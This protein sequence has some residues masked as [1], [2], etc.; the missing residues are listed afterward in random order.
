MTRKEGIKKIAE[1]GKY[2]AMTALGTYMI[3]NP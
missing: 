2:A 3:L 1:Y